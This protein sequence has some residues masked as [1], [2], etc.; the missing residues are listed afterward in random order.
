MVRRH[1]QM[2]DIQMQDIRLS[3]EKYRR[4]PLLPDVLGEYEAVQLTLPELAL[5][6]LDDFRFGA[7]QM[8][9]RLH[10]D[11]PIPDW[12]SVDYLLELVTSVDI[13]ARYP[14]YLR[15]RLVDD[16]RSAPFRQQR[17][18]R[19][20]RAQ[21]PLVALE[22]KL[23]AEQGLSEAGYHLVCAVLAFDAHERQVDGR[24]VVLRPWRCRPA[25][26]RAWTR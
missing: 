12:M 20:L 2:P 10:G 4:K 25:R 9:V 3:V 11:T 15:E 26:R 18:T 6:N 8:Q 24:P 5:E 22:L 14:A 7:R 23:R 17:F 19:Q 16:K 13:G 1:P 21:L